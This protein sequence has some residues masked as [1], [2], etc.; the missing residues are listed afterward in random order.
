MVT[1][2]IVDIISIIDKLLDT[3]YR[4]GKDNVR[5]E[6]NIDLI[7]IKLTGQ[8][9]ELLREEN[10]RAHIKE[11]AADIELRGTETVSEIQS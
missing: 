10:L 1:S 3:K 6:N 4:L 11:L 9:I 7:V 2:E 5:A 8:I